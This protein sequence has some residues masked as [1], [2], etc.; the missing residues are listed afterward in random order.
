M[1]KVACCETL[2]SGRSTK[3]QTHSPLFPFSF[4]FWIG[5]SN[6]LLSKDQTFFYCKILLMANFCPLVLFWLTL[7]RGNICYRMELS[8]D[9][10][11]ES[12]SKSNWSGQLQTNLNKSCHTFMKL[13]VILVD[14]SGRRTTMTDSCLSFHFSEV[15][16][17]S[18][19]FGQFRW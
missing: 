12:I 19:A 1:L 11:N 13:Y 4:R 5:P 6:I 9:G 16:Q 17:W 14:R 15:N 8:G 7:L 3:K 10:R 18:M 2:T